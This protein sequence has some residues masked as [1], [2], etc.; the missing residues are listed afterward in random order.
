MEK[1]TNKPFD[2]SVYNPILFGSYKIVK[3]I[4]KYAFFIAISY[5]VYEE[6]MDW[7]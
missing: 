4:L 3:K 2:K 7:D 5:Y 1:S 6:F